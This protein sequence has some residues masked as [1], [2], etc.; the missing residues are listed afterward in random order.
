MCFWE[1]RQGQVQA[2]VAAAGKPDDQEI[3]KAMDK[4]IGTSLNISEF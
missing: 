2:I 4:A 1:L 3:A